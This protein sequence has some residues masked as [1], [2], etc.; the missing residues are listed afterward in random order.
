MKRQTNILKN[1]ANMKSWLFWKKEN[2]L[3]PQEKLLHRWEDIK[4]G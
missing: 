4:P 1:S 2:G 3:S